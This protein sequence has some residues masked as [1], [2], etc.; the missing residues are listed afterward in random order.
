MLLYRL[1]TLHSAVLACLNYFYKMWF[2]VNT[3]FLS[4][5]LGLWWA[6]G[7]YMTS[8]HQY[9]GALSL[10]QAALQHCWRKE[11]V[12]CGPFWERRPFR[13]LLLDSSRLPD[14]ASST[15]GHDNKP[16]RRQGRAACE[17]VSPSRKITVFRWP[18]EPW[19]MM[20]LVKKK[21]REKEWRE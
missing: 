2:M 17:S 14:E 12:L 11:H 16:Q 13:T 15:A 1:R 21:R 20:I 6:Q 19:N 8:L 7:A 18:R 3:C 4:G 9:P 5:R 10:K